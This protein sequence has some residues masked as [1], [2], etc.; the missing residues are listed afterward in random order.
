MPSVVV[1]HGTGVRQQGY[2]EMKQVVERR[3]AKSRPQY[4]TVECRWYKQFGVPTPPYLSTPLKKGYRVVAGSDANEDVL[5]WQELYLDPLVELREL[6]R[7]ARTTGHPA[8]GAMLVAEVRNATAPASVPEF[9]MEPVWE[10]AR[11]AILS[12]SVTTQAIVNGVS[13]PEMVRLAIARAIVAE[14]IARSL[15]AGM[16]VPDAEV[17]ESWVAE[18][19]RSMGWKPEEV[20]RAVPGVLKPVARFL[21]RRLLRP[22]GESH[23]PIA[24]DILLYQAR[25]EGIRDCI[26]KAILAAE[27]PVY[28]LAHSLGGVATVDALALMPELK[29]EALITFGSQAPFFYEINALV[30]LPKGA[31]LPAHFPQRWLNFCDPNDLLSFRAGEVFPKDTRIADQHLD[32]GQPPLAA[33]S[34]YLGSKVFWAQVWTILK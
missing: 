7:A 25:G 22:F 8:R 12:D 34:S 10:S 19:R 1:I 15:E 26:A 32:S 28:L 20:T 11:G 30:S 27:A 4:R 23:S 6:A 29:A 13:Q 18:L 5:E 17:R 31:P 2:D 14:M 24:G 16:I 21:N 33:H 3:L 9:S